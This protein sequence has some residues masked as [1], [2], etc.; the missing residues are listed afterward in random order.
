[1]ASIP[2][3]KELEGRKKGQA[4]APQSRD[5]FWDSITLY[6]VA[7]ILALTAIDV[8]TEFVRGSQVQCYLPNDTDSSLLGSVQDFVN[9]FCSGRLPSLQYL[10]ALIAVHAIAILAPHYFWLNAYGADL[11]FF[12]K[13][14]SQISRIREKM[15]DYPT[16]NYAISKQRFFN[17]EWN[18][19]VVHYKT[20]FSD[21]I[22]CAWNYSS[23]CI[24]I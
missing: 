4:Q 24:A 3:P 18:V 14:V 20:V 8:I 22:L 15:G 5:F 7:V 11:D 19:L 17:S 1:M 12:F 13:H 16:I 6:I 21:D 9:E 23:A 10:P 2:D